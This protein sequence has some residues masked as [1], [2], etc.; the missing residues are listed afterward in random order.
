MKRIA[1]IVVLASIGLVPSARAQNHLEAGVFVDY[2]R[3]SETDTNFVGLGGRFAVNLV[4]HVQ[5]E[6]EMS[7]DF[8]QVFTENFSNTGTGIITST[9]SNIRVLHGLIGPKVQTGGPVR[10]FAT[11][12][13]GAVDFRFDPSPVSFADFTS[14]VNALRTNN[15]NGV[16]YPG[17]GVE[18]FLG[19]IG[20]RAE[21]G[22]EIYFNGGGHN[23]LK[24]S[25]GPT[26]RF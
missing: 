18:A 13:G 22:D 6:A 10:F 2:F 15:V 8:N 17:G 3:L 24:I 20:F 5:V 23:N 4:K 26:I 11:L 9:Q 14:S 12:K 7:Y 1:F 19:A 21:I 16:L 25:F